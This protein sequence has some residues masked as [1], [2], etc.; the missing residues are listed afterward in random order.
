MTQVPDRKLALDLIRV[1]KTAALS[2]KHSWY[3]WC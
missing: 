2:Y 3:G 1:T